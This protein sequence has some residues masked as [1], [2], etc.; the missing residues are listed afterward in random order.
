VTGVRL[1]LDEV[2]SS[3][4]SAA[5]RARGHDVVAVVEDPQ[6]RGL[7]DQEVFDWATEQ[8]RRVV[9]ENVKDFRRLVIGSEQ[10]GEPSCGC[11]FTSSRTFPRSRHNPGPIVDALDAWLRSPDA[12]R[13]P[14][15]DWLSKA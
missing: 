12:A 1:L 13:R 10:L 6:L 11:L 8:H 3:A 15:E 9:T 5:L 4:V 14:A 2:H 7:T